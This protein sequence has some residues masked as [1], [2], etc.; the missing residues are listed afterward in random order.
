MP[1]RIW[2]ALLVFSLILGGVLAIPDGPRAIPDTEVGL[3]K[4]S[5]FDTPAP[6]MIQRNESEPGDQSVIAPGF[7]DEPRLIPH[8]IGDY[9][10]ITLDENQCVDCHAVEEKEPGEP[11][12]IPRSHYVDMRHAPE[13]VQDEVAGARYNCVSCHISPGENPLLVD[14]AFGE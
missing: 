6:E 14:N 10:P 7:P 13:D 8:G 2:T 12:P 4:A 3:S 9:L 11:T 1:R 5:V